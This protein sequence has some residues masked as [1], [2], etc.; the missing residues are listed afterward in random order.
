MYNGRD[1]NYTR[2]VY[3]AGCSQ[4]VMISIS[5][6]HTNVITVLP[7]T[8][9]D[10]SD[11]LN[12]SKIRVHIKLQDTFEAGRANLKIKQQAPKTNKLRVVRLSS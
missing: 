6:V 10:Y 12:K 3:C 8:T 7:Q 4:L 1:I 11:V 2:E 9:L 5:Y